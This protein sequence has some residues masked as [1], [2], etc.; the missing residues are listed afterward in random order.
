MQ[1]VALEG[2]TPVLDSA[3]VREEVKKKYRDGALKPKE[4]DQFHLVE[5][6]LRVWAMTVRRWARGLT[7]PWVRCRLGRP[8]SLLDGQPGE[9]V[10]GR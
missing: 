10:I 1:L 8:I 9:R 5:A 6:W 2:V 3:T 4:E 7:T